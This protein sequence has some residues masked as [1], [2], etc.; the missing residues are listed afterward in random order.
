[1]SVSVEVADLM[2]AIDALAAQD[3]TT[4]PLVADLTAIEQCR[5]RLDAEAARRIAAMA[6]TGEHQA[7]SH[8]TIPSLLR[9]R[10]RAHG[11]E[12]RSRVLVARELEALPET[13]GA[14]QQGEITTRHAEEIARAR[15]AA[16]AD[17]QFDE[18]APT[19]L[20]VARA[21]TPRDVAEAAK[22]WR[23]ALDNDLDRD[24]ADSRAGKL[25]T[26]RSAVYND[27]L[28][29]L[30]HLD[31]TFAG[32][33]AKTVKRA[34]QRAYD[35][36]HVANDPR[37][38]QEQRAD[39]IVDICAAY[40]AGLPSAGN[41]PHVVVITDEETMRDEHVGWACTGDGERLDPA[42]VRRMA[43]DAFIQHVLLG[44][45]GVPLVLG[46]A[47]RLFTPDQF[48]AMVVR[49]GRCRGPDC[50]ADA[51]RCEAHHLDEWDADE[52][53][54]DLSNGALFC[55]HRCHRD[56]HD[57][58]MRVEGDANG[59]LRFYDRDGNLLGITTPQQP[60]P[61][62]RTKQGRELDENRRLVE[63]RIQQLI[64]QRNAAA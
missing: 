7:Y 23:D 25:H 56:L 13:V 1:M 22:A 28:D 64:D 61:K 18:F 47:V 31:A 10:V 63:A 4:R 51:D 62:I 12:A 53:P 9:S 35:R 58:T 26:R 17:E 29:G 48:R 30:G 15:H 11:G 20:N 19:L 2:Q 21:G 57:G 38:P 46:R 34:I 42:T 41:V 32:D 36:G 33:G 6:H 3:V 44:D 14:W 60:P 50:D 45:G 43:C 39:A 40:L 49:D 55:P 8:K 37:T 27:L 52:G 59:E 24:G 5:A 54:T 16:Q